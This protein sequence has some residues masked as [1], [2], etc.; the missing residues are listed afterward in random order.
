[1]KALALMALLLASAAQAQQT[2]VF[3]TNAPDG[4]LG[5]ASRP[6]A[7]GIAAR[8]AAD[9]FLLQQ[10]TSITNATFYGLLP[11][12]ANALDITQVS[13]EI[14][15]IFPLDSNEPPSGNVPTR[16]NGPSDVTLDSR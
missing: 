15:R 8:E 10:A 14:Y 5:M 6:G 12:G 9:D 2:V 4:R 13:V 16:L 3:S 1:M 7:V 11:S